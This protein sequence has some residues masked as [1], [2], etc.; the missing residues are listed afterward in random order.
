[1]K[2]KIRFTDIEVNVNLEYKNGIPIF[3]DQDGNKFFYKEL[4]FINS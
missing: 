1:M 4:V 2:A 3:V